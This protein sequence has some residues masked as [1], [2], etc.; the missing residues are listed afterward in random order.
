[1]VKNPSTII[2]RERFR[3]DCPMDRE[4][5]NMWEAPAIPENGNLVYTSDKGLWFGKTGVTSSDNLS[6]VCLMEPG[7]NT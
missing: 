1:M 4:G 3:M 7:K 5:C 6:R 2:T